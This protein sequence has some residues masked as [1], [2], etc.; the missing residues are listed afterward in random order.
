MLDD[1]VLLVRRG[2]SPTSAH[3]PFE[4]VCLFFESN[5]RR[6]FYDSSLFE[7]RQC[8]LLVG[9]GPACAIGQLRLARP[10]RELRR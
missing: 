9:L 2:A 6:R 1:P 4:A 8:L 7:P 5:F 10:S 3:R